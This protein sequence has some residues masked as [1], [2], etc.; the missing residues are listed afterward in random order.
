MTN[1]NDTIKPPPVVVNYQE[2]KHAAYAQ[3]MLAMAEMGDLIHGNAKEKG[4]WENGVERRNFGE[5]MMLATCEIAEAFEAYRE[6]NPTS[7]KIPGFS[8]IEEEIADVFIRLIDT[9]AAYGLSL[10]SA[11]VAKHEHNLNRPYRHGNKKA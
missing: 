10:G 1:E 7:V 8:H 11:I 3:F 9:C 2:P 4:W 5:M 6:G